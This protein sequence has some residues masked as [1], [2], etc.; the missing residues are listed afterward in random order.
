MSVLFSRNFA[1]D[2]ESKQIVLISKMEYEKVAQYTDRR[3]NMTN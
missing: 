1:F 3:G 2:F